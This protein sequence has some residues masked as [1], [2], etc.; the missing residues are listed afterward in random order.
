MSDET[1]IDPDNDALES[2]T[3]AQPF[4]AHVIDL[5]GIRIKWGMPAARAVRCDHKQ[6]IYSQTE[7]RVW[8]EGCRRS[9]DNFDA[10]L[11]VIRH[12]EKMEAD[13]DRKMQKADEALTATIHRRATKAIDKAWSRL[14][15]VAI[16]CP[17]CNG[18][19]LPEDF[20]D[21]VKTRYSREY[22]LA[23]RERNKSR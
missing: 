8:C 16:A 9:V 3:E 11:M 4:I 7:R 17:H 21:G 1:P 10:L 13:A 12:F 5:A 14:G 15:G 19:I 23:R 2:R 6:L 20:A 22:E 18:G